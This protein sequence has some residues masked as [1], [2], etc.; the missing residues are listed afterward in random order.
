MNKNF[1]CDYFFTSCSNYP[2]FRISEALLYLRDL[3]GGAAEN[4]ENPL[5]SVVGFRAKIINS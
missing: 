4:Y 3:P 1:S 5:V 2:K